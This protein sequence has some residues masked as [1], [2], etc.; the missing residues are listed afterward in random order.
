MSNTI[1]QNVTEAAE[2]DELAEKYDDELREALGNFAGEDIE[3]F[4]EYKVEILARHFAKNPPK[5][6]LEFGCGTGRNMSY[7]KDYF[8]NADIH[9]CDIS[10][11][12]IKRAEQFY[13]GPSYHVTRSAQDLIE[14]FPGGI[15]CIFVTNVFHHIP[16]EFHQE[17]LT[18]LHQ[19]LSP[20][21][22]IFIF[23]HNPYN[24]VVRV[25]FSRTPIDQD[26]TMVNPQ[27]L[28][29][30]LTDAGFHSAKLRYSLFFLWRNTFTTTIESG[31]TW[32]PVG[33]QYYVHAAK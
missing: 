31:L 5:S 24:P 22:R 3:L 21:G 23:E 12:S 19:I 16:P 28:R 15:D 18:A 33:A 4:A 30:S 7:L 20:N 2:F 13:A 26:A 25:I 10:E 17:Y 1:N 14:T 9:G 29:R 6:I 8:P 27:Y 32:L 11:E